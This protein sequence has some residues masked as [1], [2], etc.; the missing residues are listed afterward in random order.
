[1][2]SGRVVLWFRQFRY[3]KNLLLQYT[4]TIEF[5]KHV[6]VW[7]NSEF[8]VS[9]CITCKLCSLIK[10]ICSHL[11]S[12]LLDYAVLRSVRGLLS[13]RSL[14]VKSHYQHEMNLL[15]QYT[16]WM[17]YWWSWPL[18]LQYCKLYIFLILYLLLLQYYKVYVLQP[19]QVILHHCKWLVY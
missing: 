13:Y 16:K 6:Y 3:E 11:D 8:D 4:W 9:L 14:P 5:C 18:A 19:M 17:W 12:D 15:L 10:V 7:Q 2:W 1:M